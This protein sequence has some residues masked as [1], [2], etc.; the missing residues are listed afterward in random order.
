MKVDWKW[1]VIAGLLIALA[2][3]LF[4]TCKKYPEGT[5]TIKKVFIPGK[6]VLVP[7]PSPTGFV[8]PPDTFWKDVDSNEILK[9]CPDL[10]PVLKECQK[11]TKDFNTKKFYDRPLIDDSN[12]YASIK[13]TV[14]KNELGRGAFTIRLKK[15]ITTNVTYYGE[16]PKTKWWLG[17]G[18]GGD[19]ISATDSSLRIPL[20][21]LV[22]SKKNWGVELSTDVRSI[23]RQ[24]YYIEAKG[25]LLLNRKRK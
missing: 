14:Q 16:K 24:R 13:D 7:K 17:I 19:M 21:L 3:S 11:T 23:F 25:F 10:M 4:S 22:T 8:A 12:F 15:P 1:F 20:S 9:L 2:I 5:V 6:V 18:I